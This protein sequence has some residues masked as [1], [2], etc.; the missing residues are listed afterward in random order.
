MI[1]R[2][3]GFSDSPSST[4]TGNTEQ[5][6]VLFLLPDAE[7]R[8]PAWDR[9][10]KF[11][12]VPPHPHNFHAGFT[13]LPEPGFNDGADDSLTA[14]PGLER[15]W[16]ASDGPLAS[17][18]IRTER[19]LVPKDSGEGDH[20]QGLP[21]FGFHGELLLA[22]RLGR[23]V[24]PGAVR[25]MRPVQGA[26]GRRSIFRGLC[27]LGALV[28]D[29]AEHVLGVLVA[30]PGGLAEPLAGPAMVL[31]DAL[32]V[33]VD[34]AEHVLGPGVILLGG[35]LEPGAGGGIAFFN[36]PPVIEDEAE[37]VLGVFV[38]L[39]GGA[40]EPFLRLAVARGGRFVFLYSP[41]F[42]W[43]L[44]E[45]G[46]GSWAEGG[47]EGAED[48]RDGDDESPMPHEGGLESV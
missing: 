27:P 45:R 2:A 23:T 39:L 21:A 26:R 31:G 9:D 4:F 41:F 19:I 11:D 34:D 22:N 25:S 33:V 43:G 5:A 35:A 3:R 16:V 38:A 40:A 15:L 10:R 47:A 7:W 12:P 28:V 46:R 18:R 37:H 13:A 1:E 24:R 30:F 20:Q 6:Q 48:E 29:E 32:A 8:R 42:L 36:P 14:L 44:G 17:R